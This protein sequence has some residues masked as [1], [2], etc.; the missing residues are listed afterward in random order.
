MLS[1]TAVPSQIEQSSVSVYEMERGSDQLSVLLTWTGL[2]LEQAG[3]RLL[4]YVVSIYITHPSTG[5]R[6]VSIL[7]LMIYILL[8]IIFPCSLIRLM[9]VQMMLP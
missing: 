3:G 1:L 2:N 4:H 9:S 7:A 8:A 5:R 6:T